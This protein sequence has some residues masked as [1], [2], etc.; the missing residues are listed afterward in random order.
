VLCLS[1]SNKNELEIINGVH[2]YRLKKKYGVRSL[3]LGYFPEL[4]KPL[5]KYLNL[6]L[7]FPLISENKKN[8]FNLNAVKSSEINH[9]EK[10]LFLEKILRFILKNEFIH[11]FLINVRQGSYLRTFY[12]FLKKNKA[13]I[14]YAHELPVLETV[15]FASKYHKTRVI[16]DSHELEVDRN[17]SWPKKSFE[18]YSSKEK[19]YIK[20]VDKVIVV[21]NG[22]SLFMKN[23]Y[24]I[25]NIMVVKNTPMLLQQKSCKKNLRDEINLKEST[26]LIVYIGSLTFNRGIEN[27]L[28]A[29]TKLESYHFACVGPVNYTLLK[30]IKIISKS[31][32]IENRVH[33]IRPVNPNILASYVSNANISIIPI[34]NTCKSHFYCLPNKIFES[35]YAGLPILGANLNDIKEIIN[36]ENI[37]EVCDMSDIES[38]VNGIKLIGRNKNYYNK[39]LA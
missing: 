6:D 39:E 34:Q 22:I 8:L 9:K 23:F 36:N 31:L 17:Q 25:D 14:L 35:I 12:P 19:K 21:S 1:N 27:I 28:K 29:L 18:K 37:G 15:I 30:K 26:P 10:F 11:S 4:I 5:G 38:I 13:A 16:Y 32:K 20:F 24:N 2:Y 33:L 7:N 3:L